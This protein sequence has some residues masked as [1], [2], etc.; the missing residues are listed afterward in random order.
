MKSCGVGRPGGGDDLGV[1]RVEPAVAG[2]SRGPCR[3]TASPPGRR[4]RS[5]PRRLGDGHVADVHAVDPDRAGGHVPQPRDEPDQGRLARARRP[6][7]REGLPCRDRQRHVAQDEPVRRRTRTTRRRARSGRRPLGI[8]RA[9]GA[10]R[11][12]GRRVDDLEHPGDRPGPLPELA[13]QPGDRA[14]ARADRDAVQQEPGQGADPELAVD[15]LVAGVP[16]QAGDGAEAE[17]AHQRPE[18]ARHSASREPVATTLR[19]SA[20]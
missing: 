20:S 8:G 5:A 14:E 4:A 18:H 1:G 9:S 19:R 6:D 10:S 11:I 2:C 13:V 3:R 12:V 7:Q 16:Q 17:E 15:D